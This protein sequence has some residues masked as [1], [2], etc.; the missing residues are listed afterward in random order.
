MFNNK[1]LVGNAAGTG[2]TFVY[3]WSIL[4]FAG[5][6][7]I[8]VGGVWRSVLFVLFSIITGAFVYSF[9]KGAVVALWEG[10]EEV[11]SEFVPSGT[12]DTTATIK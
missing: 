10:D 7:G 11:D 8:L 5:K 3:I 9:F 1:E 4:A 6:F 2:A 12:V